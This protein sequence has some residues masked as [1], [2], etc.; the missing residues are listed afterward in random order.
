MDPPNPPV[1][2]T[3]RIESAKCSEAGGGKDGVFVVG[4]LGG[5]TLNWVVVSNIFDFHP[6]WENDPI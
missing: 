1:D 6:T 5:E 4:F 2:P 3:H